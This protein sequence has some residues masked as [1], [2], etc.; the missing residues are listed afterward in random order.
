[1]ARPQVGNYF[2]TLANV[3]HDS[4][5]DYREAPTEGQQPNVNENPRAG[6]TLCYSVLVM[7][8]ILASSKKWQ[9]QEVGSYMIRWVVHDPLGERLW[10]RLICYLGV[11]L[12]L[13]HYVP[14]TYF[15]CPKL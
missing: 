11:I 7:D 9:S 2:G 10:V 1:M 6:S 3:R 8:K 12:L 5:R 15:G 4:T 13:V 14:G